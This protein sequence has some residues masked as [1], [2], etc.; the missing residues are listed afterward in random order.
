MM[1]YVFG[2]LLITSQNFDNMF[3]AYKVHPLDFANS[4]LMCGYD[5]L[6]QQNYLN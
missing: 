6:S 2:N 1:G 5:L 4:H 3:L